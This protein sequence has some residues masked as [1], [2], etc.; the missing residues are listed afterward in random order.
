MADASAALFYGVYIET[1][2]LCF[3]SDAYQAEKDSLLAIDLIRLRRRKDALSTTTANKSIT[4]VPGE[5]W[6]M[7]KLQ[8]ISDGM[9]ESEESEIDQFFHLADSANEA[10]ESDDELDQIYNW[11]TII[12]NERFYRNFDNSDGIFAMFEER[13]KVNKHPPF[14]LPTLR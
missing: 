3:A 4:K 6:E 13:S 10:E 12:S 1:A 14:A 11:S 5:V 8:I 2:Y 9:D 7:I